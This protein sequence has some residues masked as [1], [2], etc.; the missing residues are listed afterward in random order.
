MQVTSFISCPSSLH[1]K[2][3]SMRYS[4]KVGLLLSFEPCAGTNNFCLLQRT[5]KE[6]K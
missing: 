3:L 6:R 5:M 4:N 1:N 2:N